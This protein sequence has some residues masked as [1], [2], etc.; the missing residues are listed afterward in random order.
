MYLEIIW[1][2][3]KGAHEDTTRETLELMQK[4]AVYLNMN[5]LQFVFKKVNEIPNTDY[6][7]ILIDFL[8]DYTLSAMS[9]YTNRERE[10]SGNI[11][12]DAYKWLQMKKSNSDQLKYFNLDKF[13]DIANDDSVTKLEIKEKAINSLIEILG[14]PYCQIRS[15]VNYLTCCIN[16]I[17]CSE[18]YVEN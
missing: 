13:W 8:K 1:N 15:K 7:E 17:I 18:K 6:N 10:G 3:I 5:C 4:I 9:N 16:N 14:S 2:N 11:F 12:Q